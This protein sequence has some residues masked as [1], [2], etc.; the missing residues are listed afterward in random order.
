MHRSLPQWILM[1]ATKASS[2]KV[3]PAGTRRAASSSA[4]RRL[5][6][7]Q[8]AVLSGPVK[9]ALNRIFKLQPYIAKYFGGFSDETPLSAEH[10]V[11]CYRYE[12][13]V[14]H[15]GD[16]PVVTLAEL[17][18]AEK[19]IKVAQAEHRER[20][21]VMRLYFD[22][23]RKS[24]MVAAPSDK[25]AAIDRLLAVDQCLTPPPPRLDFTRDEDSAF[26]L[27]VKG[28]PDLT[29]LKQHLLGQGG[30]NF[31]RNDFIAAQI[32]PKMV[33]NLLAEG[34][35]RAGRGAELCKMETS[36]CHENARLLAHRADT[37]LWFGFALSGGVWRIHSWCVRGHQIIETTD[38]RETYFGI[39]ILIPISKFVGRLLVS[40]VRRQGGRP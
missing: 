10:V 1:K 21:N 36:E 34:A 31:Q 30:R 38:P 17:R 20:R 7:T 3:Y 28:R 13:K 32:T 29:K 2:S 15:F 5:A 33:K 35:F 4:A 6:K 24:S 26:G 12:T 23:C 8:P 14:F 27:A 39:H 37:E 25:N 22:A 19:R 9:T 18:A 40:E 16:R 11:C